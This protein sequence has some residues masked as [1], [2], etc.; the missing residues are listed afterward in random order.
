MTVE[1]DH[2]FILVNPKA[3]VADALT[4]IGMLEGSSND[5]E[6]Q[7]TS[8]RRFYFDNGMLEFLYVRDERE[9]NEGPAKN[10]RFVE[11]SQNIDAS[12]FGIIIHAGEESSKHEPFEGWK[13]Q[14]KYFKEGWAFHVGENSI[15]L[16]EPLC[17]YVPFY[18]EDFKP[19][20]EQPLEYN[21]I[22]EVKIFTPS[23]S[24]TLVVADSA[25]RLKIERGDHHAMEITFN[26]GTQKKSKDFNPKIPLTIN[27]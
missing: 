8:N 12:P 17:I 3:E 11:R 19:K 10:L 7:G 9:A 23:I 6:G 20:G 16:C 14:P 22:S 13:Y 18:N 25:K 2:V 5:H 24:K 27:W 15:N 1:L 26:Q 21:S 4:E